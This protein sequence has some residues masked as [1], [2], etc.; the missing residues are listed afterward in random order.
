MKNQTNSHSNTNNNN[1]NA[2]MTPFA[3]LSIT[4]G[5]ITIAE[6]GEDN[7]EQSPTNKTTNNTTVASPLVPKPAARRNLVM[8]RRQ[9]TSLF[10]NQTNAPKA[11]Q[12]EPSA[13]VETVTQ[14]IT[15]TPTEQSSRSKPKVE[16][17]VALTGWDLLERHMQRG[18]NV[19][20]Q[21]IRVVKN[22]NNQSNHIVGVNVRVAG[23]EAFAPFRMLGLSELETE[24]SVTL[25][26]EFR[27]LEME[28]GQ[29][30]Q[31]GGKKRHDRIILNHVMVLAA[32][33]NSAFARNVKVGSTVTGIIRSIKNF[34]AFLDIDGASALIHVN[35]LPAGNLQSVQVGQTVSAT[36]V[37]IDRSKNQIGVS[38]RHHF[39]SQLAVG[40]EFS[41]PVRNVEDYGAFVQVAGITDGLIHVSKFGKAKPARG[42]IATV[43]ILSIDLERA[44]IELGLVR[45]NA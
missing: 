38:M 13:T 1:S 37:K 34:G 7:A 9:I 35:D 15:P 25:E 17:T 3:A 2:L 39:V 32:A 40:D 44:K 12:E 42:D 16:A 45:L 33:R 10:V 28:K 18:T 14:L 6:T 41:G 24:Q 22:Q 21:I 26:K 27:V 4:D 36:V 5:A 11:G 8:P 30:P 19:R 43:K 20:G 31:D 23:V 29:T